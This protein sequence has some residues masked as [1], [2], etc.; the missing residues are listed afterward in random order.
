[1]NLL[2]IYYNVYKNFI[3]KNSD[4]LD[5]GNIPLFPNEHY[6]YF[7]TKDNKHISV[8]NLESKFRKNFSNVLEKL[9]DNIS[10]E[11]NFDNV[12]NYFMKHNRDELFVKV[13]YDYNS[14]LILKHV[15]LQ[16]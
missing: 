6:N 9:D 16:Y 8:G 5:K 14:F 13:N 3:L 2:Y 15:L 7:K 10:N 4:E 11:Y 1:M 12:K